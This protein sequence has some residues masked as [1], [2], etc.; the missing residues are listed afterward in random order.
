MS[1]AG[2]AWKCPICGRRFT[3]KNQPHSCELFS[4]KKHHFKRGSPLTVQMYHQF[5]HIFQDFGPI[6]VESLKHIIAIKK[7]SQFCT[8]QM[9]KAALKIIFRSLTLFPSQ[10]LT[11]MSQSQQEDN[12]YYYQIKIQ[13]LE[14]MDEEL[15]DW[16]RQ[17]YEEN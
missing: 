14:D 15:I 1:N 3:R 4:L 5:I 2:E 6:L 8:I 10:R 16:F 9:Q 13:A 12:Y 11:R 7:N 17:A